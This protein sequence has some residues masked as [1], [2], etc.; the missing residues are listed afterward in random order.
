[1]C[2]GGG[3]VWWG[4]C[5]GRSAMIIV[6]WGGRAGVIGSKCLI[7]VVAHAA[8]FLVTIALCINWG[9]PEQALHS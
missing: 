9:E 1:M 7:D 6:F 5:L 8:L 2:G 4:W 3:G